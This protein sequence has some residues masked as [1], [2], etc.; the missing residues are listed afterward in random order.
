MGLETPAFEKEKQKERKKTGMKSLE[1]S[2]S[3]PSSG[4]WEDETDS[5]RTLEGAQMVLGYVMLPL[6]GP[7]ASPR[8][9]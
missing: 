3:E 5:I 2:F 8:N 6:N 4:Y 7:E 9:C 1:F